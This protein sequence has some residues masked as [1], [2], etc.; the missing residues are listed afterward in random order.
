M[1]PLY[2]RPDN[3]R[4]LVEFYDVNNNIADSVIF[5]DDILFQGENVSI[6]GTDNILSGSMVIGSALG[7]GIEMAGVGSGFVR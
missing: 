6:R 5:S 4:F 2:T 3:V 7:S 1:T